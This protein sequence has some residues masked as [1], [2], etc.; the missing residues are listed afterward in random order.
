LVLLGFSYFYQALGHGGTADQ[1]VNMSL[2]IV[3]LRKALLFPSVPA[4]D[5]VYYVLGKSYYH[6]GYYYLDLSAQYLEKALLENPRLEN[7]YEYLGLAYHDLGDFDR[8][9]SAFQRAYA[10]RPTALL[11]YAM[12][13][14]SF[15]AGR[16]DAS[17]EYLLRLESDYEARREVAFK[18]DD[19]LMQKVWLLLGDLAFGENQYT[20]AQSF[21]ERT[22]LINESNGLVY[23]KLGDVYDARDKDIVKARKA[24]RTAV[25]LDPYLGEARER[26]QRPVN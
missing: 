6:R 13:E 12:A 3:H 25:E 1:E 16:R 19:N 7:G 4:R 17:R 8:S 18:P 23:L 20:E 9:F 15:Q 21:Y 11:L 10:Q 5:R 26:L 14:A 22:L 2:A 24:W